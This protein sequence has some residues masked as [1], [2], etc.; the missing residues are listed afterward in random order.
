MTMAMETMAMETTQAKKESDG[1][2]DPDNNNDSRSR[3]TTTTA[4]QQL[5]QLQQRIQQ[6]LQQQLVQ[7]ADERQRAHGEEVDRLHRVVASLQQRLRDAEGGDGSAGAAGGEQMAGLTQRIDR[8]GSLMKDAREREQVLQKQLL[9]ASVAGDENA[10]NYR[11]AL[12][13]CS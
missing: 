10:E 4:Q 2:E 8:L 9:E 7:Q 13:V 1:Q 12:Q 5:Q 6:Q 3:P 11:L